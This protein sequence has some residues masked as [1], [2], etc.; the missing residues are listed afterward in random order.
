MRKD[1][2]YLENIN[3][4][5]TTCNLC[6]GMVV[7]TTNAIIYGKE[8]GSGKMY[9]CTE[10]KAFVDTQ[11]KRPTM[12]MGILANKEMR[13][14]KHNCY[15]VFDRRWKSEATLEDRKAKRKLAYKKLAEKL[16][17]PVEYCHFSYFNMSLLKEAYGILTHR[18]FEE[19]TD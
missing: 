16:N 1:A 19:K 14:M 9:F 18:D 17:I 15:E 10:C 11:K 13:V 6:D 12:A 4:Q 8:C 2:A 3:L 7:L 5:P